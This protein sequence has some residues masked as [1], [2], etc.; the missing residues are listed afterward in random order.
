MVRIVPKL[1]LFIMIMKR[2][3]IFNNILRSITFQPWKFSNT[4]WMPSKIV[5]FTF[6][7]SVTLHTLTGTIRAR[8][9]IPW[10][11]TVLWTGRGDTG[12]CFAYLARET[13]RGAGRLDTRNIE[14]VASTAHFR[15][16]KYRD[17]NTSC[18][19]LQDREDQQDKQIVGDR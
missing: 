12:D 9:G 1:G 18:C 7:P 4:P 17:I 5:F 6:L 14:W 10:C 11:G 15:A 16:W 13:G 19:G 3:H 2:L 8:P